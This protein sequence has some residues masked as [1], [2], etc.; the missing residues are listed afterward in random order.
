VN[1]MAHITG[2]GLIDNLPRVL[3]PTVKAVF[4]QS[5]W[6]VPPLVRELVRRGDLGHDER[7]RTFNMGVGFALVIP[8]REVAAALAAVAGARV[9]GFIDPRAGDEPAVVVHAARGD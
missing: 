2:G 3:P 6:T 9:V 5:R 8:F 7:Y 4:E 1:V